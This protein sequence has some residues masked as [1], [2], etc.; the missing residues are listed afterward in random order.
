MKVEQ[1]NL[2]PLIAIP[3]AYRDRGKGA[4]Y[5]LMATFSRFVAVAFF[6]W[7]SFSFVVVAAL[8][9]EESAEFDGEKITDFALRA[10]DGR[11]L[12]VCDFRGV[13]VIVEFFASGSS[14]CLA[15]LKQLKELHDSYADQGLAIFALAVDQFETQ[16]TDKNVESLIL[17]MK[18]PFPVG[19]ATRELANDYHYRGVPATIVLDCEGKIARTFFGF[20]EKEK[21][22]PIIKSL[23]ATK[24]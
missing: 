22:E 1:P 7:M 3:T 15:Q 23:L 19:A 8:S 17:I 21:I 14:A 6:S 16:E 20:H 18:L 10:R 9:P 24:K 11:T 12:D 13:P 2:K 5:L 4:R